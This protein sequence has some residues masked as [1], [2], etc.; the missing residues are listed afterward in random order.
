MSDQ[1][2]I[3]MMIALVLMSEEH[4]QE[5]ID[6]VKNA[7]ISPKVRHFFE[8]SFEIAGEKRKMVQTPSVPRVQ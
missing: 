6:Y 2:I 3:E 5:C 4:F 7:D 8:L 1:E